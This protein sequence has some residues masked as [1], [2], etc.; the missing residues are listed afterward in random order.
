V[1]TA[2]VIGIGLGLLAACVY[3]S[4]RVGG[5]SAL[6]TSVLAFLPLWLIGSGVNMAMGSRRV[7]LFLRWRFH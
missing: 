2:I 1:Q 5:P 4:R 7:A 6:T 3:L